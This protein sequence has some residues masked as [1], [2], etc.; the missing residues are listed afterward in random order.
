MISRL[1]TASLTLFSNLTVLNG[2]IYLC[3]QKLLLHLV[4]IILLSFNT[5]LY[6][7]AVS[8]H[9]ASM[10]VGELN[11]QLAC[12]I[13]SFNSLL[14][15]YVIGNF[16][17]VGGIVHQEHFQILDVADGQLLESVGQQELGGLIGTVSNL[18]HWEIASEAS[19]AS[20]VNTS[21]E[22]PAGLH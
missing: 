2:R 14:G 5:P 15:S 3:L 12:T 13:D 8:C 16:S 20:V 17:S 22:S 6:L 18:R 4:R 1:L 11:I 7:L 19:T 10:S 9:Q 21:G